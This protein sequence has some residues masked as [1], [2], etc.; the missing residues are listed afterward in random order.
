MLGARARQEARNAPSGVR[1][2]SALQGMSVWRHCR[3]EPV[4]RRLLERAVQRLGLS[5][6]GYTR[7]LKVARTIADLAGSEMVAVGHVAEALQYRLNDDSH[8]LEAR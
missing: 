6:R 7:V 2:N 3:P 5:A 1:V 4:A 8:Q